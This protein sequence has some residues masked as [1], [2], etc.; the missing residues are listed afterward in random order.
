MRQFSSIFLFVSSFSAILLGCGR[1]EI[2]HNKRSSETVEI[3]LRNDTSWTNCTAS[4]GLSFTNTTIDDDRLQPTLNGFRSRM[5]QNISTSVTDV[6]DVRSTKHVNVSYTYEGTTLCDMKSII[7]L[8]SDRVI[9]TG[10]PKSHP[11]AN[12]LM[13]SP[14][15]NWPSSSEIVNLALKS[16]AEGRNDFKLLDA[17]PCYVLEASELIPAWKLILN[18][19]GVNYDVLGDATRIRRMLSRE[20]HATGKGVSYVDNPKTGALSPSVLLDLDSSDGLSSTRFRMEVRDGAPVLLNPSRQ[21]DDITPSDP[22]FDQIN[23]F[24]NAER[25][26]TWIQKSEHDNSIGCSPIDLILSTNVEGPGGPTPDNALYRSPEDTESRRPMLEIGAGS[27]FQNLRRDFDVIAHELG[28]HVVARTLKART[29]EARSIHEGL[30]DYLVYAQTGDPCLADSICTPASGCFV[31]NSCLRT[32]DN[33]LNLND[34]R[35]SDSYGQ[36]MVISS[37]FWELGKDETI[38]QEVVTKLVFTAVDYFLPASDFADLFRGI[39]AADL[40][41]NEGVNAC[42]IDAAA[43]ER[44]FENALEGFDCKDFEKKN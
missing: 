30:A 1:D 14:K 31:S 6:R 12:Q 36:A 5:P 39:Y 26:M 35:R 33:D 9:T 2:Y 10:E 28:H 17:E 38:T 41:L 44:G 8:L 27:V 40:D 42:K 3:P 23:V 16:K 43:R 15:R 18:V 32:A 25:A 19:A 20:T 24:T 34:I 22:R 37:L 4:G 29:G 21:Y 7:H 11:L 13:P